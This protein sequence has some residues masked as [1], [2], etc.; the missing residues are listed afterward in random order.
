[1]ALVLTKPIGV[2]MIT[3][4]GKRG[5]ATEAQL[6]DALDSHDDAERQRPPERPSR[7]A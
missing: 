3:T 4:A 1:M 2:G 7:R 5:V 6:A